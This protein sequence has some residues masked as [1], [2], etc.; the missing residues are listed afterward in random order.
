MEQIRF[1]KAIMATK[2]IPP[3]PKSTRKADGVGQLAERMSSI[4]ERRLANAT[5]AERAQATRQ[6]R[7]IASRS[8]GSSEKR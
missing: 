3:K 4:L 1:P 2:P 5:P 6:L 8:R 7:A